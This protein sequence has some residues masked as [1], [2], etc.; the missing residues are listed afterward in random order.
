MSHIKQKKSQ[1]P[2]HPNLAGLYTIMS[3]I[4]RNLGN[5]AASAIYFEKS[6]TIH[7]KILPR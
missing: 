6:R 5:D 3:F 2:Q 1:T 4:Y 7:E